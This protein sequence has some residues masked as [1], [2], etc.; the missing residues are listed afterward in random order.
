MAEWFARLLRLP[1][2][3]FSLR[4]SSSFQVPLEQ[5]ADGDPPAA[6]ERNDRAVVH[7]RTCSCAAF[8]YTLHLQPFMIFT[9]TGAGAVGVGAAC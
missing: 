9:T 5:P 3:T 2:L 8:L 4:S 7:V 1:S 6:V